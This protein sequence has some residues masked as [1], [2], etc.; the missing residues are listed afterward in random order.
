[1]GVS[2]RRLHAFI[3]KK[4]YFAPCAADS[5]ALARRI[6]HQENYEIVCKLGRGKYSEVFEGIDVRKGSKC[7]IKIL[8][9]MFCCT[10]CIIYCILLPFPP[11][12]SPA[13][14]HYLAI[15]FHARA[16][17]RAR[18]SRSRRKILLPFLSDQLF[19]HAAGEE[20]ED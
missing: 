2:F 15:L 7:V 9:V 17:R 4:W 5:P 13:S 10:I 1:M 16:T 6:R 12:Q 11:S 19:P 18:Q 20:E 3:L 14:A 8:K